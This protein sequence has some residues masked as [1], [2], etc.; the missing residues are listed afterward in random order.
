MKDARR[1][2][3]GFLGGQSGLGGQSLVGG[4]SVQDGLSGAARKAKET[5]DGQSALGKGAIA[6]GLAALLLGSKGGR[7]LAGTAVRTGGVALVGALA[8]RAWQDWQAGKSP[9]AAPSALPAPQGTPFLPADENQ[10]DDLSERLLQAMVAAAKADGRVTPAER[11]RIDRQMAELGMG[12]EAQALVAAELDSPLDPGRIAGL[13]R[14]PEEA[15]EIYAASLLVVDRD[16]AA[17]KGYLAML[18]ARLGLQPEL[19]AHLNAQGDAL[20]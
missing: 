8:Y 20:G 1:L 19:V 13:A 12:P 17:E 7:K 15:A 9:D 2:I 18:A 3:E 6:G 5:W 10:A 16:G 11:L 4:Q 14:S